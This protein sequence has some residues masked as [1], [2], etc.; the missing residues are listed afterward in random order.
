MK[1]LLQ[2]AI[3]AVL[4]AGCGK[5][6]Q[7]TPANPEADIALL[8]AAYD[9]NIEAAKQQLAEGADVNVKDKDYRNETPLQYAAQEGH[10]K[11]AEL[12]I[13]NGADVNA[14]VFGNGETPLQYAVQEGHKEIVELLIAN[15]ADV[16]AL[17][18]YGAPLDEAVERDESEIAD[19]LRKHG[20][21]TGEE[22][23]S[24]GK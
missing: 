22:L 9:G 18:V 6:Q 4:L 13:A 16:N 17:S 2:T 3:A 7:A 1:H 23:K 19:L 8:S 20:A 10:T 11:V 24:E 15:D 21:K 14:K 5:V 12:L